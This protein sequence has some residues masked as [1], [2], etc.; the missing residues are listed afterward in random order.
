MYTVDYRLTRAISFLKGEILF[1]SRLEFSIITYLV[2]S[3]TCN[4]ML[5]ILSIN[6]NNNIHFII[7]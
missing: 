4:K 5:D 3:I 6:H 1:A 7:T 2:T